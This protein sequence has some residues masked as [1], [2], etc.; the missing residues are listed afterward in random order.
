MTRGIEIAQSTIEALE[1]EGEE[2]WFTDGFGLTNPTPH[3]E[4]NVG[5][6]AVCSTDNTRTKHLGSI[7]TVCDG[8]VYAIDLALK[9]AGMIICR[10]LGKLGRIWSWANW[11]SINGWKGKDQRIG[12]KGSACQKERIYEHGM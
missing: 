2:V 10:H 3:T 9:A 12:R 4:W 1:C 7:A 5:C 6:A 11:E 8:E